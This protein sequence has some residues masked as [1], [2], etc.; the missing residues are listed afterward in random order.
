MDKFG[1]RKLLI[2]GLMGTAFSNL[3]ASVGSMFGSAMIM[4][5]GF[6]L[7]KAFTGLGAGAPS[8]FLT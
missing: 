6:S 1:N 5:V 4:T 8:W 2:F 3:I 7:T